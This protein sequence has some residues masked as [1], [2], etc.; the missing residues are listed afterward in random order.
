MLAA[1]R[2]LLNLLIYVANGFL[3]LVY[4]VIEHWAIL[5]SLICGLAVLLVFDRAIQNLEIAA[6]S[7]QGQPSPRRPSRQHQVFT[8][9][10]LALWL[11]VALLFP[12]PVPQIGAGMWVLFV[13][14]LLL[15]P[16]EQF[17]T[18]W[19]S[20]MAIL[21]YC[22]VLVAFRIVAAWTLAADPREWASIVGSVGE[23]QRVVASGRSIVLSIASY[24]SWFAVPGGYAIYFFQKLLAHPL[25][26]PLARVGEIAWLIRQRPD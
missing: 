21:S 26:N 2:F 20:K 25:V 13:L 23:A 8:A 7:R 15:V 16:A 6:P 19:R 9:V 5:L 11:L 17:Q 22:G 1:G 3:Y 18:L 14:A 4:S 12:T 24:A 10:V